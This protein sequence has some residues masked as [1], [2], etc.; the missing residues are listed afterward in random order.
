MDLIPLNKA[1]SLDFLCA[2]FQLFNGSKEFT[3]VT[4]TTKNP[5]LHPL[6]TNYILGPNLAWSPL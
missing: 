5:L 1:V 4:T 2:S 6:W 3:I